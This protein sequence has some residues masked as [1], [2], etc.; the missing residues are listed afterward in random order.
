MASLRG[1]ARLRAVALAAPVLCA[2]A[3]T[4]QS[5]ISESARPDA[6]GR[7]PTAIGGVAVTTG[8]AFAGLV[9][10]SVEGD[11]GVESASST[12]WHRDG[13]ADGATPDV[14]LLVAEGT[15]VALQRVVADLQSD[16]SSARTERTVSRVGGTD[17]ESTTFG[18]P[19]TSVNFAAARPEP[20]RLVMAYSLTG[21]S[22]HVIEAVTSMLDEGPL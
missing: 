20:G 8:D 3:L 7:L 1:D 12:A 6:S 21:D 9:E 11:A 15:P 5:A 22:D 19:N 4:I 13:R 2:I 10:L 14:V 17:V 16:Y 18:L